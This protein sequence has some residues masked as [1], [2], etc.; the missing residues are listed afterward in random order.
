MDLHISKRKLLEFNEKEM[1]YKTIEKNCR[2]LNDALES[3][4][5]KIHNECPVTVN[6][7]CIDLINVT[8]QYTKLYLEMK[9]KFKAETSQQSNYLA[10]DEPSK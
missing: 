1:L 9:Q 4:L 8:V 7:R 2:L 6:R 3:E 5:V 10:V